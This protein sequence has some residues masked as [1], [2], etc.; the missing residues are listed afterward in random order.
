MERVQLTSTIRTGRGKGAARQLRRQ[1]YI[2]AVLY[3]GPTGNLALSVNTHELHQIIAKGFG[4]TSLIELTIRDADESQRASVILKDY[5]LD[6]VVR[7]LVHADFQEVAMDQE[8]DIEVPI[9]VTGKA[10]G[11]S[12][13]GVLEF[14]M[15]EVSIR[16]LPGDMLNH[17]DVDVSSL[18]IGDSL[19]VS[20]L[21]F[22]EKYQILTPAETLI[23][24]VSVPISEEELESTLEASHE[25]VEPEVIQKG[26]KTEEEE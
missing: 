25:Q 12:E 6:P 24:T 2:P 16:C 8:I 7:E 19:S 20:D 22:D 4:E 15:R 3:G 5:Q 13:G 18:K 26:K 10:P 9:E 1:G 23:V 11:V 17:I 14:L 21:Q